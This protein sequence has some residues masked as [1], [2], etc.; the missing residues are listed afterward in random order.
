M[1]DGRGWKRKKETNGE[2]DGKGWKRKRV[3]MERRR[4]M[5]KITRRWMMSGEDDEEMRERV[6]NRERMMMMMRWM[7]RVMRR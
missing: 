1:D 5:V 4:W 7:M 2:D 6:R 3:E